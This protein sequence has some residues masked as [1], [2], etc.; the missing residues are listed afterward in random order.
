MVDEGRASRLL[1]GVTERAARLEH[2]RIQPERERGDLWLDGVKYLF[3]TMIEG[4]LDV[5]QHIAAS[6]KLGVPDSN[7]DAIRLLGRHDIIAGDLADTLARAA[8]FRN[9]LVHGYADVD[10]DVVVDRLGTLDDF[11]DFVVQVSRWITETS[12]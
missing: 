8:G 4:C 11:S 7:A 3:V 6:E 1:R 12:G 2:A 9:V 5:A 10:D